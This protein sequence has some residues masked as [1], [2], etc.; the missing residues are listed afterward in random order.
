[1]KNQNIDHKSSQITII[2][3]PN[4]GKSTLLNKFI[5]QKVA[6]VSPKVQTTR[7]SIA[8]IL[9]KKDT[10][11]VFI[12]TPGIFAANT[13]L[14]KAMV[15]CAWSQVAGADEVIFLID[16][17]KEFDEKSKDIAKQLFQR[18]IAPIFVVNKIDKRNSNSED[19]VSAIKEIS[20][21]AKIVTISA[22]KGKNIDELENYLLERAPKKHWLYEEDDITNISTKFLASE[23]TREQLFLQMQEEIPYKLTVEAESFEDMD[24]GSIKINQ[25]IIVSKKNYKAMILGNQGARIKKIGTRARQELSKI[26]DKKIHLFLFV[27]VRED[28]D[29]KPSSFEYMGLKW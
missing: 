23:I 8:G 24:D 4:A 22:L 28:W 17:C 13:R 7:S 5:G 29:V 12:D 16:S 26:L 20:E 21:D 14:E 2:G 6:I 9:T 27:K 1:M 25:I 15:R 3:K 19:M 18:N 11:L 10:Q